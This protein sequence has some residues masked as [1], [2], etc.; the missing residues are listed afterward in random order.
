M[1]FNAFFNTLEK[2]AA[3]DRL[4]HRALNY[5]LSHPKHVL[6]GLAALGLAGFAG[7]KIYYVLNEREK[8]DLQKKNFQALMAMVRG[9]KNLEVQLPSPGPKKSTFDPM[10]YY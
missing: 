2:E 10:V 4:V 6:G 5:S 3:A 7:P 8:K 1:N 9:R